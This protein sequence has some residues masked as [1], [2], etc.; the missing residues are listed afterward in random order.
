MDNISLIHRFPRIKLYEGRYMLQNWFNYLKIDG[1]E[2]FVNIREIEAS[3]LDD[4]RR[5]KNNFDIV[6]HEKSQ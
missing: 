5:S 2:K 3:E 6:E 4:Y 1:N